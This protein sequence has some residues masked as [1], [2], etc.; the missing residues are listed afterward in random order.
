MIQPNYTATIAVK[1][2]P[3]E[4]FK[5]ITNVAAWWGED[6]EGSAYYQ[7]DQFTIHFGETFVIFKV[8]ESDPGKL[9]EWQV[10]DCYLPWLADKKEWNGTRP[11]FEITNENDQ[12]KIVF[13]HIGLAPGIE[14]YNDC[15][16]GWDQYVKGSLLALINEGQGLPQK[17]KKNPELSSN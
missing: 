2:N 15:I 16:K 3:E 9:L 11:R 14:C 5:A 1:Q 12:T 7:G 10:T 8:T 17:K 13:T 6:I 4:A